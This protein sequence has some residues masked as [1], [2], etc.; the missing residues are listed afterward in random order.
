M[1]RSLLVRA[2][3]VLVAA[4][5]AL[6]GCGSTSTAPSPTKDAS[7]ALLARF[8]LGGYDAVEVIDHLDRLGGADRPADLKASVRPSELQLSSGDDKAT[9]P[10][11]E[12][13][14]YLSVAPYVDSTHE[15]FYHSLT[16]CKGELGGKEVRVRI[17]DTTHGTVL[18]DRT[19]TTFANGFVGFW[20]PRDIEGTVRIS[21]G[22]RSAETTIST[23]RSAPTCLTTLKLV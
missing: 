14:F 10:I 20:L 15:C 3:P 17:E 4:A 11:P 1:K 7:T 18:V 12:G 19:T 23:D 2:L 9:L 22:G 16:T 21:Y 5:L 6:T 13:R 8:G